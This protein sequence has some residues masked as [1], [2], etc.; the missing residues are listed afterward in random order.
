M[1]TGFEQLSIGVHELYLTMHRVETKQM[2]KYGLRG[3]YVKYL[4]A[5]LH[6]P[7]GLTISQL[8]EI[9]DQDKAAVSRAVSELVGREF[10]WR[11][12]PRKNHYRAKLN[13]SER[14]CELAKE[15]CNSAKDAFD[16]A[17]AGLTQEQKDNLYEL[18]F[19]VSDNLH[20]IGMKKAERYEK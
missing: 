10:I 2:E 15:V 11:D 12:N 20:V 6:T 16:E 19:A 14:G 7:E 1:L 3:A 8:C 17:V 18:M 13:L 5:L 9:C 4:V